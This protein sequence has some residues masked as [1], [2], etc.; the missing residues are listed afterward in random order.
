MGDKMMKL[1]LAFFICISLVA[2]GKSDDKS[3]QT[4]S[5]TETEINDGNVVA[6]ISKNLKSEG[7][8][9]SKKLRL[10]IKG[11]IATADGSFTYVRSYT[12]PELPNKL[13]YI[14]IMCLSAEGLDKLPIDSVATL[15]SDNFIIKGGSPDGDEL[16]IGVNKCQLSNSETT[17]VTADQNMSFTDYFGKWAGSPGWSCDAPLVISEKGVTDDGKTNPI[18]MQGGSLAISKDGPFLT[19]SKDK[20]KLTYANPSGSGDSFDLEKCK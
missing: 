11:S 10:T 18:E 14:L 13:K 19:I 7:L 9:V 15:K 5:G 3:S 4:G 1:L 17:N 2:C 20:T 12:K 16:R 6:F 8:D